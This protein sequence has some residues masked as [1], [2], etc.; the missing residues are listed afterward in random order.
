MSRP[1]VCA[2][3]YPDGNGTYCVHHGGDADCPCPVY[4]PRPAPRTYLYR[5]DVRIPGGITIW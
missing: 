4:S 5:Q 2:S 3:P 1:C